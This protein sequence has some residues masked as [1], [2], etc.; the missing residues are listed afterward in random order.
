MS[1]TLVADTTAS[2]NVI[3]TQE[4]PANAESPQTLLA[5]VVDDDPDFLDQQEANLKT[6]GFNVLT[7]C[8]SAGARE[9]LATNHPDVAV[10][11]LMME[12]S[13]AGFALCYHLKQLYP[14]TPVIMVTSAGSITGYDFESMHE[15]QRRWV[16]A[17]AVFSKPMRL[18][19]LRRELAR[20]LK[21]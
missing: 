4:R 11:D 18:E 3:D 20:L 19:Q 10:V 13:D 2:N 14:K 15:G 17:D 8:S 9:L 7:A 21:G 12:N 5:L 1:E 16:H 6:L